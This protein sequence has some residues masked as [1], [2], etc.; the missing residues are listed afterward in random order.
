MD[1]ISYKLGKKAG[2]GS[3]VNNQNKDVTITENGS[4]TV[5]A[6]EG[7][8]GLGTVGITTNVQPDLESKS[9]TITENT[10]TT[11]TPTQGKDGLSQVSIT[12]NVSGGTDLSEYFADTINTFSNNN[13]WQ[14]L[15]KKIPSPVYLSGTNWQYAFANFKGTQLPTIGTDSTN[16]TD[17]NNMFSNAQSITS[18]NLS[19]LNTENVTNMKNMFGFTYGLTSLNLSNFNTSKV[20]DMSTMFYDARYIATLNISAFNFEKCVNIK[21]IFYQCYGLINLT[22]GTNL[23]KGYL[24][25]AGANYDNYTLNL[26]HSTALTHDSLMSVINGLYDI[27]TAGVQPQQLV[28]GATNL[29]KLSQAEIAI[30]TNKGWAVS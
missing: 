22:F 3:S 13:S 1:I 9:V 14:R 2:G 18:L 12:T 8:T 5:S 16:V 25:S 29:A 7:Y 10:T 20:T 23:G 19:N 27:A 26:S 30:A 28:L 17:M 11:I 24:T 4:T 6:D 15:I 21:N